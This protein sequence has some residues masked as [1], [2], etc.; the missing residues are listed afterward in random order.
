M[1]TRAIPVARVKGSAKL[2][3]GLVEAVHGCSWI[4]FGPQRVENLVSAQRLGCMGRQQREKG[5]DSS[6][7]EVDGLPR[8]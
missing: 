7:V 3:E 6:L 5:S 1:R 4:S 2:E 8:P